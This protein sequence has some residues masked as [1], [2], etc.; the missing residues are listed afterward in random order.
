M[1]NDLTTTDNSDR[2]TNIATRSLSVTLAATIPDWVDLGLLSAIVR[3]GYG[4]PIPAGW[5]AALRESAAAHQVALAASTGEERQ[6]I[7]M[8]LRS[9]TI[10]RNE[11]VDEADATLKMLRVHLEDV[12]IDILKEAI[13]AY[14]NAPGKRFFPRSAGELREFTQVALYQRQSRVLH[15]RKLADEADRADVER[16][17]LAE[18]P[19]TH[20]E[21][22]AIIA[23][24]K[25]SKRM[26]DLIMPGQRE[27]A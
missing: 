6:A 11:H 9:A 24:A 20:E 12:P 5:G 2:P 22:Q 4:L 1:A 14:C 21:T 27:A 3:H 8:A 23:K 19:V 25:L 7:L 18:G 10:I 17:R 13:R 16:E 26:A 15:L